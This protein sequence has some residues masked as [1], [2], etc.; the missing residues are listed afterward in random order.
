M[1][2]RFLMMSIIGIMVASTIG[3][4]L[5]FIPVHQ[6][7]LQICASTHDEMSSLIPEKDMEKIKELGNKYHS[8]KC[9]EKTNQWKDMAHYPVNRAT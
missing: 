9:N 1:K 4:L 8:Y 3:S 2:D 7:N 6:E 5:F